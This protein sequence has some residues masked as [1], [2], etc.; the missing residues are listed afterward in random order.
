VAPKKVGG[1]VPKKIRDEHR[2][3]LIA[4]C[5]ERDFTLR[6]LVAELAA[7]GLSVDYRTMWA[8]VHDEKL[9]YKKK[10]ARA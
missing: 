8:F 1:N 7:R 9:S 5:R 6:G 3:W 2:D 10:S 4:R